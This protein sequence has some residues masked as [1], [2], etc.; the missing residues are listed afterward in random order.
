MK[1][2]HLTNPPPFFSTQKNNYEINEMLILV[3]LSFVVY[4][5][6]IKNTQEIT[7]KCKNLTLIAKT[8]KGFVKRAC[9]LLIIK[10][11]ISVQYRYRLAERLLRQTSSLRASKA[12][13]I[14]TA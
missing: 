12:V 13:C 10:P 3:Q 9:N 5:F 2:Q 14:D 8:C 11:I 6:I 7:K 4:D 1:N